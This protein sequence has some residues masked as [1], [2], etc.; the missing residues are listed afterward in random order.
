MHVHHA[1]I[2]I[3]PKMNSGYFSP[4]R[5]IRAFLSKGTSAWWKICLEYR[6]CHQRN[7]KCVRNKSWMKWVLVPSPLFKV[8]MSPPTLP[9]HGEFDRKRE[10]KM[11]EIYLFPLNGLPQKRNTTESSKS[12]RFAFLVPFIGRS[13]KLIIWVWRYF[14]G[15][16]DNR[17]VTLKWKILAL[18]LLIL[19]LK[20]FTYLFVH[21]DLDQDWFNTSAWNEYI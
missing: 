4:S 17:E 20:L 9:K 3:H 8:P 6:V 2:V 18:I 12:S 11:C 1:V 10:W 16:P 5:L 21:V 13:I 14:P 19:T 15:L 7:A